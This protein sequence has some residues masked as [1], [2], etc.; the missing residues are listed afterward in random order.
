MSNNVQSGTRSALAAK[1]LLAVSAVVHAISVGVQMYYANQFGSTLEFPQ[2]ISYCL[3]FVI[4]IVPVVLAFF[5]AVLTEQGSRRGRTLV[6]LACLFVSAS[7]VYGMA[8]SFRAGVS[9]ANLSYVIC[10]STVVAVYVFAAV[11]AFRGFP[12]L[13]VSRILTGLPIPVGILRLF[14]S[15]VSL[16]DRFAFSPE[17][18]VGLAISQT[19]GMLAELVFYVAVFVFLLVNV[20]TDKSKPSQQI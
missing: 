19:W 16:L 4:E 2:L 9:M 12:L 5:G 15:G 7:S 1:L 18:I 6:A 14:S 8:L 11:D 10:Q 13:D 20:K 17:E 3:L